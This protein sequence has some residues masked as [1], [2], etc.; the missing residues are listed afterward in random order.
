MSL[1]FAGQ[2]I[3]NTF[4]MRADLGSGSWVEYETFGFAQ[5]PCILLIMGL[6][7][8]LLAWR[9]E[10]CAML[11]ERGY[12]VVRFDNR[13]VGLSKHWDERGAPPLIRRALALTLLGR[14]CPRLAS[15][16]TLGDMG[17]DAFGLLDHLKVERA[18]LVGVSMGG[19]I[20]Q[21]MALDEPGRV[22]SLCSISES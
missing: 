13:D 17:A 11:V 1:S 5:N 14:L 9:E 7:T 16:Y 8:S 21:T 12:F 10:F 6:G 2:T 20:A 4:A 15:P 19:M 18:N 3:F 22:A